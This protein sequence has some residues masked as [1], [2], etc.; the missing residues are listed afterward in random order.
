LK[1]LEQTVH[2]CMLCVRS[3]VGA[4]LF[5]LRVLVATALIPGLP[6]VSSAFSEAVRDISGKRGDSG[7]FPHAV[8]V[9]NRMFSRA[10]GISLISECAQF[11][12]TT[13]TLSAVSSNNGWQMPKLFKGADAAFDVWRLLLSIVVQTKGTMLT[14]GHSAGVLFNKGGADLLSAA[15]ALL[16]VNLVTILLF[17]RASLFDIDLSLLL[18]TAVWDTDGFL[19]VPGFLRVFAHLNEQIMHVKDPG[20]SLGT[21]GR[22]YEGAT[23]V[24]RQGLLTFSPSFFG[25]I[26]RAALIAEGLPTIDSTCSTEPKSTPCLQRAMCSLTSQYMVLYRGALRKEGGAVS[27]GLLTQSYCRTTIYQIVEDSELYDGLWE[28]PEA[29][30]EC[31]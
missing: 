2:T 14:S 21:Q 11:R 7:M 3:S 10:G 9:L 31:G 25:D 22:M 12:V 13:A 18:R 26:N 17:S 20:P 6:W 5:V 19:D 30:M 4:L 15:V 16:M 8:L 24:F 27:S 1:T 23:P 29:F 28:R